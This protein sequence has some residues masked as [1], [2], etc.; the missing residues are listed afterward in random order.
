MRQ[1][2]ADFAHRAADAGKGVGAMTTRFM[3][4]KPFGSVWAKCARAEG[5]AR[6]QARIGAYAS[7]RS[8]LIASESST[9]PPTRL[10]A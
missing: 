1:A 6:A 4:G 9:C 3:N 2:V 7:M 8:S 5:A 10:V